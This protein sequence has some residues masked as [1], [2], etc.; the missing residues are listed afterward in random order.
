MPEPVTAPAPET[1]APRRNRKSWIL[2]A[3]LLGIYLLIKVQGWIFASGA[4]TL[5]RQLEELRPVLSAMALSE[6]LKGTIKSYEEGARQIRQRHLPGELLL[7]DLSHLP[8][9][10]VLD[11]VELRSEAVRISGSFLAG[12]RNPETAL[13]LWAQTLRG[14]GSRVWIRKLVPLQANPGRW[15]FELQLEVSER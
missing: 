5:E 6:Q 10:F 8:A 12:V 3:V 11:H 13:V 9:S 4:R 14:L 7:R 2:P 15:Q 1:A